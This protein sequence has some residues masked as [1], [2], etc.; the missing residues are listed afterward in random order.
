MYGVALAND[1]QI[2]KAKKQFEAA[3]KYYFDA[4]KFNPLKPAS[5]LCRIGTVLFRTELYKEAS[6]FFE[7]AI[8]LAGPG[9]ESIVKL[10][11]ERLARSNS[12]ISALPPIEAPSPMRSFPV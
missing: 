1:G 5:A 6:T 12:K 2:L 11:R 3:L 4:V 10:S 8:S 9:E 7:K